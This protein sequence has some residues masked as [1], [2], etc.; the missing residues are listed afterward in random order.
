MKD[1]KIDQHS[2]SLAASVFLQYYYKYESQILMPGEYVD[3]NVLIVKV[4]SIYTIRF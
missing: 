4:P 2:H 3:L 1:R